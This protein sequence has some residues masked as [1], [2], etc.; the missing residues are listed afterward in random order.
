MTLARTALRLAAINSLQGADAGSGPTIANN[1]VYDSR[2]TDF[3][4]ETFVD[5]AK[6]TV[7]VLTDEDEGEALSRQNAGPPFHRLIDLV[8]EI[9]IVQAQKDGTGFVVGYPDT[10]GRHEASLDI[11][12]FQ[13]ARRLGY[14]PDASSVLFRSFVRPK[15]R[16]CHRQVLD[17][18]GVKIA[19]RIVTWTCEVDDD[20]VSVI[21]QKHTLPVGFNVLPEPLRRVAHALSD[22]SAGLDTCIAVA[23]ALTPLQLPSFDDFVLKAYMKDLSDMNFSADILSG[24][25]VPQLL[26]SNIA[27][28]IDYQAG[29][30]DTISTSYQNLILDQNV[31]SLSVVGWP[32]FGVEAKLILQVT[33]NGGFAINGW[34]AG[35]VWVGGVAPTIT[36]GAGHKDIVILTT[37]D[38]GQTIF[39]NVV[40]QDYH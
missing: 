28:Q 17:D 40:G 10:D 13:L 37:P 16:D 25:S 29:V 15:K 22:G 36:L 8:F 1:R 26:A 5:D 30:T 27:G 3:S 18:A 33:N 38:G 19:C 6:P 9:G 11:L 39:G 7:I 12:E 31:A 4:P 23:K 21:N 35:T 2:I 32:R 14:D 34:P 24:L 20:Q